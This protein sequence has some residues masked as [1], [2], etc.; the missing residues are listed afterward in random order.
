M[1]AVQNAPLVAPAEKEAAL[2]RRATAGEVQAIG[3]IIRAH[4]QRLCRLVRAVLRKPIPQDVIRSGAARF[5]FMA[6]QMHEFSWMAPGIRQS[7]S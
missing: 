3:Q 5:H 4:S 7:S 2:I 6:V 1:P